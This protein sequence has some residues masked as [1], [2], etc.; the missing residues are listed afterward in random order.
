MNIFRLDMKRKIS[1]KPQA[2]A[3]QPQD[4]FPLHGSTSHP[5]FVQTPVDRFIGKTKIG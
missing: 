4:S 5:P 2:E 1:G 3:R